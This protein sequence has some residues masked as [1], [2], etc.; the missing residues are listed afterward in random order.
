MK[1]LEIRQ[2]K[3]I[4]TPGSYVYNKGIKGRYNYPHSYKN[5]IYNGCGGEQVFTSSNLNLYG[6]TNDEKQVQTSIKHDILKTFN[7]KKLSENF[8][9]KLELQMPDTVILEKDESG[10]Y[11]L[12]K[13]SCK[14]IFRTIHPR[15]EFFI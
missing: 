15:K 2:L 1:K 13:G 14:E 5:K 6:T 9:E 12:S 8:V 3:V 7:R 11:H 10:E 4:Y